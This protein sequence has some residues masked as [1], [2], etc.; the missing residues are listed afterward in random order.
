MDGSK[1]NP[2]VLRYNN[3]LYNFLPLSFSA[4]DGYKE[5]VLKGGTDPDHC[6]SPQA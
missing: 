3:A 5:Y 6:W 2:V 4:E 1:Q